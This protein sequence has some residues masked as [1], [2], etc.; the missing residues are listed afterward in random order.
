[1][2]AIYLVPGPYQKLCQAIHIYFLQSVPENNLKEWFCIL[3]LQMNF[4]R[5]R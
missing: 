2:F 4:L 3:I 1:M 5:L